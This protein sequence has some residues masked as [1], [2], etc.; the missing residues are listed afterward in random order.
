[1][2]LVGHFVVGYMLWHCWPCIAQQRPPSS[3]RIIN[4]SSQP[5]IAFSISGLPFRDIG[6][7]SRW[8]EALT[9][10]FGDGQ[11]DYEMYWRLADGTVY[12]A[13]LDFKHELPDVF[14]GDV[15]LSIRNDKVGVSWANVNAEW[16]EYSRV[17]DPTKVSEPVTPYYS[18]CEGDLLDDPDTIK[19]WNEAAAKVRERFSDQP[20]RIEGIILRGRCTL[21]WYIPET[22]PRTRERLDGSTAEKLRADWHAEI[23]KH[24][25]SRAASK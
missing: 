3:I 16:I 25:A 12:G 14:H 1:M 9:P 24:K 6:L 7:D 19:A 8:G 5:V 13:V 4:L 20:E 23:E 21:D 2:K 17:G 22:V 10:A 11:M 18:G 15:I